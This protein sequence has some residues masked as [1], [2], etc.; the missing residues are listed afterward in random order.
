MPNGNAGMGDDFLALFHLRWSIPVLA[1]FARLGGQ[2]KFVTLQRQLGVSRSSLQRTL[3]ALI[4]IGLVRKNEGYG[5]PLRPEYLLTSVG[6]RVGGPASEMMRLLDRQQLADLGLR[7]WSVPLA[8]AM[9]DV[10]GQFNQLQG[11]LAGISP[12]ALSQ[13][14]SDLEEA[15]WIERQLQDGH[16][17][18]WEYKLLPKSRLVNRAAI[19]LQQQL[20]TRLP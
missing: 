10:P 6:R 17:P 7:K 12:R 15:G 14:L 1:A 4:E 13:A 5:H 3:R 8:R 18:R 20:A 16:P 2:A 11:E 19:D 9:L